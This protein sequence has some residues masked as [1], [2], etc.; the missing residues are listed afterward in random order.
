MERIKK[1]RECPN[2]AD[3]TLK[4]ITLNNTLH[5]SYHQVEKLGCGSIL[6]KNTIPLTPTIQPQNNN[7]IIKKCINN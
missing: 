7:K 5:R 1:K 3:Y 6:H 2:T 4:F